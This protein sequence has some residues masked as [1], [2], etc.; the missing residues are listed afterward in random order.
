MNR[1]DV[2]EIDE[3]GE[4]VAE[5]VEQAVEKVRAQRIVKLERT[6]STKGKTLGELAEIVGNEKIFRR[7][8]DEGVRHISTDILVKVGMTLGISLGDLR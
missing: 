2:A 4:K 1:F 6:L 8:I 5:T 3:L 7:I